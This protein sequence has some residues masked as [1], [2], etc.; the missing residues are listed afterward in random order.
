MIA[1]HIKDAMENASLEKV[2]TKTNNTMKNKETT[3]IEEMTEVFNL[4]KHLSNSSHKSFESNARWKNHA[5]LA[6]MPKDIEKILKQKK[7][8]WSKLNPKN[9]NN[10]KDS[11]S[12]FEKQ[13]D[14]LFE[15]YHCY[16]K[17]EKKFIE[18]EILP[19]ETRT[20]NALFTVK[21]MYNSKKR[22]IQKRFQEEMMEFMKDNNKNK[23][24]C[25]FL[26]LHKA[27]DTGFCCFLFFVFLVCLHRNELQT[28]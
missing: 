14:M 7:D 6:G 4:I 23:L 21:I 15:W 22:E 12:T 19:Y 25:K 2:N 17:Y 5:Q 8:V 11:Q 26:T 27:S 24:K 20:Q 13:T 10:D 18:Q 16:K 1:K 9:W 3:K 28:F